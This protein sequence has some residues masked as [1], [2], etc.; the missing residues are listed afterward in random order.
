MAADAI[1][2][3]IVAAMDHPA[4]FQ[5]WFR[6]GSS[7]D[8]WR[9]VLKAAYGLPMSDAEREF[10]RQVAEREPPAK[11]VRELWI[12][13]G[14]RAGKDSIASLITAHAA[15]FFE[16][17][18]RLRP[19]ERVLCA[20]LATD[21]D[22]ARIVLGYTRSYFEA[23]PPLRAMVQRETRAGFELNNGVDIAIST[24]SFRNVRG[25]PILCAVL[26][27]C[28]FYRD[29]TSAVPDEE[30]YRALKPG[31][32]TLSDDAMLIGISTPYR[33]GGLL[34]KKFV[35]HY[36][37]ASD[38]TLV[39]R[40][41][42]IVLNRTLDRGIIAQALEE[43]PAAAEAE[44]N[45]VWR[46]DIETFI[47]REAL[48]A[49]VCRGRHELGPVGGNAYTAFVDPAGGSG[50]DAMTLAVA[51]HADG[52]SVLCCVRETRPVFSPEAVVADFVKTLKAY[53]VDRVT[54]DRWGGEFVREPFRS[55]GIEYQIA[56]RPKSDFY[57]DFLPLVNSGKVELLDNARLINQLVGL[58]RRVSRAG[59]DSIDHGPTSHDDLAN[60]V[61]AV[62]VLAHGSAPA[63]WQR[64]ALGAPVSLPGRMDAELIFAVLVAD[65]AGRV[66]GVAYFSTGR[67]SLGRPI[68]LLDCELGPLSSLLLHGVFKRLSDLAEACS[69][70]HSAVFTSSRL[71]EELERMGRRAEVV[72]AILDDTALE[73]SASKHIAAQRVRVCE[74]VLAKN[75]PLTFLQGAAVADDS[76]VV[77]LAFLAGVAAALD[78][79]RSLG[80]TAA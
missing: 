9:A 40:A 17:R 47:D 62:L 8:G 24:N 1:T 13:A 71:A 35:A 11:R 60:S 72:D 21:R 18:D 45:A 61:S 74:G 75:F 14:R 2:L 73:L 3:D 79:G 56:D 16:H 69:A 23:I 80:R 59:K 53:R 64:E 68:Y 26:D 44:W 42:S 67:L 51:C 5:P 33:K 65:K 54:G 77:R 46:S 30:L 66:G 78:T 58:E 28:A 43:D 12:I 38:D 7:W 39:I 29:E 57:R 37:K 4:L 20:C 6:G 41:P 36:G 50:G 34:Y 27:E 48:D 19:G 70:P 63:L 76:D 52:R 31:M 10:F 25:R 55:H 32:A 15:T 49:V 22:Q